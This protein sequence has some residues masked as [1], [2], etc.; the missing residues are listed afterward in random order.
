[1]NWRKGTVMAMLEAVL[2]GILSSVTAS[3]IW[4]LLLGRLRPRLAISTE[5]AEDPNVN[6][7][8]PVFRIK[9]VNRGRYA[10]MDL[11][12]QVDLVTPVRAKGG[13]VDR[14][15]PL[16]CGNAPLMFPRYDRSGNEHRNAY[17]LRID[18]DIRRLLAEYPNSSIRLQIFARHELSGMGKVFEQAY[19]HPD[20]EIVLGSFVRGQNLTLA[21][22]S[23]AYQQK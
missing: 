5:I 17:R 23:R 12:F 13:N 19:N 20:S 10:A 22:E 1:M 21:R 2:V 16:K 18:S 9:V 11:R 7:D 8:S 6:M 4:M 14:R 15:T 3:A